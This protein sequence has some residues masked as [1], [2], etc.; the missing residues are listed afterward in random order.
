MKHVLKYYF[1]AILFFVFLLPKTV[2][3]QGP[4]GTSNSSGQGEIAF[5]SY[6]EDNRKI[7]VVNADGTELRILTEYTAS[8]A[9]P[10]W[11]PDG[12]QI[13]Y[14]SLRETNEEIYV[15]NAD[16]TEVH[17][18]TNNV[19]AQDLYPAWSPDG[20]ADRVQVR[21]RLW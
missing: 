11:S 20:G 4:S 5:I 21:P 18:L 13:A 2:R 14:Q 8:D 7:Y 19:A 6:R 9:T 16:G 12:K 17:N 10:I 15:V 3:S 1:A